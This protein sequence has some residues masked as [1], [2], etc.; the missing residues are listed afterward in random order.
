MQIVKNVT[1]NTLFSF[2]DNKMAFYFN[3]CFIV[4]LL[5]L[6]RFLNLDYSI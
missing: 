6:L 3:N 4:S 1:N 2:V 5:L